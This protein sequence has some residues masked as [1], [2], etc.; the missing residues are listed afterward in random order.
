MTVPD[1][2]KNITESVLGGPPLEIGE[3]Y[4]H[5]R[6]G[7]IKVVAGQYWG[8]RGLSN[9]WSWQVMKTGEIRQGYGHE[10]PV[11]RGRRDGYEP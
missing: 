5:P 10:W 6:D 11:F 8:R 7:V 3:W 2:V 1:W 4:T 9:S